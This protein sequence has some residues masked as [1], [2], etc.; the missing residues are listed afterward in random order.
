MPMLFFVDKDDVNKSI[1]DAAQ[2]AKVLEAH[3]LIRRSKYGYYEHETFIRN[4]LYH[5][6]GKYEF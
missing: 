6:S 4:S 5:S 1:D 3:N 2:E